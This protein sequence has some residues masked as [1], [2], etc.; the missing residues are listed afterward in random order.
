MSEIT[1]DRLI[2][3]LYMVKDYSPRLPKTSSE[4]F[5]ATMRQVIAMV[6][7]ERAVTNGNNQ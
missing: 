1:H 3:I 4:E 7:A 2:E 6:R 5:H